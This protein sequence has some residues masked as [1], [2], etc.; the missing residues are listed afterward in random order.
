VEEDWRPDVDGTWILQRFYRGARWMEQPGHF[1]VTP[2]D[3]AG[4]PVGDPLIAQVG[5]DD[6]WSPGDDGFV[7]RFVVRQI[8][9][10]CANLN[11]LAGANSFAV[12]GLAQF[13]DALQA[14][15][16]ALPIPANAT[17]LRL[18][19]SADPTA[20]RRVPVSHAD[21]S[22]FPFGYGFQPQLEVL[23]L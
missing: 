9:R 7:R 3:P 10:H 8:V 21:P 4:N 11:D 16:R 2:L 5:Q 20:D 15:R 12:Q 23:N 14:D 19:W 1:A 18:F 17:Q 13:R 6:R 22:A